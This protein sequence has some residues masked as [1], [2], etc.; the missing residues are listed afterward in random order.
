MTDIIRLLVFAGIGGVGILLV[1][2]AGFSVGTFLAPR[3][4]RFVAGVGSSLGLPRASADAA[5]FIAIGVPVVVVG[6]G[7]MLFAARL[8]IGGGA[9]VSTLVVV[10]HALLIVGSVTVLLAVTVGFII[11]TMR[12][13]RASQAGD[14]CALTEVET[15]D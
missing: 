9:P 8:I 14:S 2:A 15:D 5:T 11:G 3:V 7:V 6:A 1:A 10:F 4:R 13:R 12:A